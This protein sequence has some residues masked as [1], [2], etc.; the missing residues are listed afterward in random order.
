MWLKFSEKEDPMKKA[1][2]ICVLSVF[3][4]GLMAVPSLSQ[5]GDEI[6]NK[7]I[8]AMG[9][10]TA[11]EKIKD[12]TITGSM[13][14]TQMGLS[15]TITV[16]QKEPNKARYDIE[17]MGM[18]ISQACDGEIAWGTNPQTGMTEEMP[19]QNAEYMKRE[20]L[21]NSA[22]LNPKKFGITFTFKGKENV[23]GKDCLVLEQ[24]FA[25]GFIATLY[26]DPDTYLTYKAKGKTLNQ[27]GMEVEAET[28][29]SDYKKVDGITV[30][31]SLVSYQ[32]GEEFMTMT[33]SEVKFNSGL[34]DNLFAMN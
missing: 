8:E 5:T 26:I 2:S 19:E 31:H 23:G 3:L 20:S 13:D 24:A 10:R 29:L 28:L 12:T 27:M 15:G 30:A 1:T 34:E 9:G 4:I 33:I 32:D 16:Y 14:L 25:D 7:M 6:L 22:F 11:L 17:V 21:G 18:L